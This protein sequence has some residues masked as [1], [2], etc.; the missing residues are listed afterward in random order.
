MLRG[1]LEGWTDEEDLLRLLCAFALG[2]AIC[3]QEDK[4]EEA[5]EVLLEKL[6]I[7]RRT[8]GDEHEEMLH[9]QDFIA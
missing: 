2:V 7:Q 4:I 5:V 9:L 1:V 3:R 8:R 6:E